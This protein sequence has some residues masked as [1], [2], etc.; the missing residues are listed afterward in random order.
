[1][2]LL[3]VNVGESELFTYLLQLRRCRYKNMEKISYN[4]VV[5]IKSQLC[6]SALHNEQRPGRGVSCTGLCGTQDLQPD[7][8]E[9]PQTLQPRT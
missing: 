1:M 2:L 6:F 7:E 3:Q 9:G 8:A 4:V 5:I